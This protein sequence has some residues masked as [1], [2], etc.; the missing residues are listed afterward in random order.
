MKGTR[1]EELR[2]IPGLRE[3]GESKG[4][5]RRV[6]RVAHLLKPKGDVPTA[7]AFQTPFALTLRAMAQL[8]HL[9]K[10]VRT[11]TAEGDRA[12]LAH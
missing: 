4:D 8:D 10:Y 9:L 6:E 1:G 5:L 3:I 11:G 7:V 12:F 2:E